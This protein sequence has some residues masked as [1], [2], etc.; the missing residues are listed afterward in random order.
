MILTVVHWHLQEQLQTLQN[1]FP[2][3]DCTHLFRTLQQCNWITSDAAEKLLE[4][5]DTMELPTASAHNQ[6]SADLKDS[7]PDSEVNPSQ[8]TSLVQPSTSVDRALLGSF[9]SSSSSTCGFPLSP[10][11]FEFEA[12]I[13]PENLLGRVS[14]QV[15]MQGRYVDLTIDR[16]RVWRTALG[17]YKGCMKNP[18]Q[19]RREVRIE[20]EREEGVDAGALRN[21]FYALLMRELDDKLFEGC[22]MSRLPRKDSNLQRMFETAGIIM[23]HSI[24]QGGPG[25]PCL[26]PAAY[27]YM[28]HLDKERALEKLPSIQDIPSNASTS[29]LLTLIEEVRMCVCL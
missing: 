5:K 27:S 6:D 14:Q 11:E 24:L 29:G 12:N 7:M 26:C 3:L 18:G 8:A 17:F 2:D 4:L 25:F 9:G 15:L 22:E 28:L 13:S 19:L 16:E 23:A 21:E 10:S 1:M 20:F